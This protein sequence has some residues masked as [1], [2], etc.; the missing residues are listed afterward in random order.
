[1][2]SVY[3]ARDTQLDRDVALKVPRIDPQEGP[4]VLNRF[5]REAKAAAKLRHPCICPT[6][7]AGEIDGVPFITMAYLPGTPLSR[8]LRRGKPV[9]GRQVAKLIQRLADALW[10]AHSHGVI[11]RD[12]KPGNIMLTKGNQ[13]VI[14]DFGLARRN[15]LGDEGATRLTASGTI[16]GTPAYMAP[17]QVAGAP[18][19]VGPASDIYSLGVV[20]Y[21]LLTGRL[22][23]EGPVGLVFGQIMTVDPKSPSEV[24]PKVDRRLE[25]TCQRAMAKDP[26]AR[27]GSMAEFSADLQEY[28]Q[29]SAPHDSA[30]IS[31][32]VGFDSMVSRSQVPTD[33]SATPA[34]CPS[35]SRTRCVRGPGNRRQRR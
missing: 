20:M 22:P 15:H 1:M 8:V 12:L 6:Y 9:Q 14:M 30:N 29:V 24:Y 2:G 16:L 26:A 21:E 34:L 31:S 33:G 10:E 11:H 32:A 17:E 18:T 5:Y 13:P 7:D 23:F 4:G 25:A 27:F 19:A 35:H 3:L 28:L